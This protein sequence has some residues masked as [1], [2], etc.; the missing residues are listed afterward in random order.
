MIVLFLIGVGVIH[1]DIVN[2]VKISR[3]GPAVGIEQSCIGN[4]E[5]LHRIFLVG[6]DQ[7]TRYVVGTDALLLLENGVI[8]ETDKGAV[9]VKPYLFMAQRKASTALSVSAGI[10]LGGNR[11]GW[12]YWKD[13]NG[14]SLNDNKQ[15][16]KKMTGK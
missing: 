1:S 6:L 10:I 3:D 9:F 13:V 7:R 5:I 11:N 4:A 16:K 8:K 15:L 14:H 2:H 12:D